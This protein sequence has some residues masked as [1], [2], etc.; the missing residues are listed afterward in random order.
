MPDKRED[1]TPDYKLFINGSEASVDLAVD[2]LVVSVSDYIEGADTFSVK[3]NNW[4]AGEEYKW[5][6]AGVFDEGSE[7]E[8]KMGY[9]DDLAS[10]IKGEVTAI[11]PEYE[12]GEAPT[13]EIQGYDRLH[14]FRRGKKSRSFNQVKDSQIAQQIAQEL[15]LKAQ[16]DDT[17]IVHDYLFQNNQ[18][19]I[20]FL[21]ERA[22]RIRYEVYVEDKTLFFKKA[23]NNNGKIL[24]IEFGD[25]LKSFF[26]RLTTMQ[27]VSEVIVKGWNPKT[28][29]TIIGRARRGDE[30][31]QMGGTMIG[32]SIAES[33]FGATKTY[34]VDKPIYTQ[35]EAEQ[36][37]KA[38]FN[39]MI[40]DFVTGEGVAI[41][42][43]AIR[44]GEVI[45]IIKL[46]TRFSGLYYVTSSTHTINQDGYTT[47]FYI[48]RNA[49]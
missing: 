44:A 21:Q 15:Q 37:A 14:S 31:T 13:I 11:E 35:S 33:A 8:I 26:P 17:S 43:T 36:I 41:G 23:S 24:T 40:I 49:V 9:V 38:K 42:N 1:N 3:F 19:D 10:M 47:K 22:K 46:G 25:K 4:H 30:S 20:D 28:K 27:Q 18:T 12:E 45:E 16:V 6:D 48:G 5:I 32:T 29:E 7:I 39:D 2:I 34:I